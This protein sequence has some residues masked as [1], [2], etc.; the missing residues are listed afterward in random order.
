[1]SLQQ[2]YQEQQVVSLAT[3]NK[4]QEFLTQDTH[5]PPPADHGRLQ[6]EGGVTMT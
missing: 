6:E 4:I 1:M 3:E 5:P 2:D